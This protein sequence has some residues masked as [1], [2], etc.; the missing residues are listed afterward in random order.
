MEDEIKR[1]LTV[2]DVLLE[3]NNYSE[4]YEIYDNVSLKLLNNL[5]DTRSARKISKT[6]GWVAA[7]LTGGFGAE[8]FIVVPV[9]NKLLLKF[10][11]ID[12]GTTLKYLLHSE[13]QKLQILSVQPEFQLSLDK[14][15]VLLT[16]LLCY[17]LTRSL[18]DK[19]T[20]DKLFDLVNP[21]SDSS[22][23]SGTEYSLGLDTIQ[24]LLLEEI[25]KENYL[26]QYLNNLLYIYLISASLTYTNLYDYLHNKFQYFSQ[27]KNLYYD[28]E[29]NKAKYYGEI[30]GLSGKVTKDEIRRKYREL[31]KKY[32]PDVHPNASEYEKKELNKKTMQITEAFAWF[33]KKYKL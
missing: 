14:N 24:D 11:G 21:L 8:D 3:Q 19:S 2:A 18:N 29:A 7:F 31:I 1:S 27:N 9:V 13:S 12:L 26:T 20:L 6:A 30:L 33:R 32:H 25:L 17:R 4:A 23:V 5:K 15:K 22:P 16:F 28:D 10:L